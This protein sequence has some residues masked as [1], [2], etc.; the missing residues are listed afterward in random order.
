MTL[1]GPYRHIRYADHVY[2]ICIGLGYIAFVAGSKEISIFGPKTDI[3]QYLKEDEPRP[4][5]R[6]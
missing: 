6:L 4:W 1:L 3:F 2:L 5:L